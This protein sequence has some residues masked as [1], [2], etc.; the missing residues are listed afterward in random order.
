MFK[1]Y[2]KIAVKNLSEHC[3]LIHPKASVDKIDL[4]SNAMSLQVDFT[5]KPAITV[6]QSASVD[7][8]LNLMKLSGVRT[9][10]IIDSKNDFVGVI[11]AMDIMGRKSMAYANEAGIPRSD[12]LVKNIM[13]P[14]NKLKAVDKDESAHSTVGGI[15]HTLSALHEQHMLVVTGE[16]LDMEVCGLY[17]ASDF[18]RELGITFDTSSISHTFSDLKRVIYEHK[19]V[20]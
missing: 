9:L 6:N 12:V 5:K 4:N 17:S 1:K 11:T 18:I 7:D 16:G 2:R 19:E 15:M 20:P 13:L 10:M 3:G 8:A 14:K